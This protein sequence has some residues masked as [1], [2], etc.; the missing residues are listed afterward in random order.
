MAISLCGT[1]TAGRQARTFAAEWLAHGNHEA[2]ETYQSRIRSVRVVDVLLVARRYLHPERMQV[3][4]VGPIDAIEAAPTLEDEGALA[5]YGR[6]VR[7]R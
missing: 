7:R 5:D 4:L 1:V 3:V 2:S 6:V